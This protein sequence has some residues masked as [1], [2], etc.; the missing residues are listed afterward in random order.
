LSQGGESRSERPFVFTT[1]DVPGAVSTQAWGI[2]ARG[3]I[4]GSY[5]DAG[6]RS[7]GYLLRDGEFTT[8]DFSATASTEAHGI[9]PNGEIVGWYRSPAE[10]ATLILH[11]FLRTKKGVFVA[12]DDLPH[13]STVAN[14]ILP[15]G[16]ILGCRHELDQMATM[17]GIVISR[18]GSITERSEYGSMDNGGTPDHG[19]VV[20]LYYNQAAANRVEGFLIDDGVFTPLLVPGSNNTQAW[21][22]NPAGEIVGF[23]RTSGVF[24][25]FVLRDGQYTTFDVPGATASRLRGV[26]SRGDIV[27]TYTAANGTTHGF[28]ASQASN[29]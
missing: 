14:R 3:D 13:I 19:R 10:A 18:E 1:I 2:N 27:G 28:L 22:I 5:V 11:G 21:D 23:Y 12:V 26:N 24:H 7:H 17:R 16:T 25:G 4:V 8:I 29:D 15:D 6:S 9:G 20:G